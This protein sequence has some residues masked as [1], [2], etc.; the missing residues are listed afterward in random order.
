MADAARFVEELSQV[1]SVEKWVAFDKTYG[2]DRVDT[3]FWP[4]TDWLHQ[5][6]S[7][8]MG[9]EGGVLDLRNYDLRDEAY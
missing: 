9:A 7:A 6:I 5:W 3:E 1:D 8:N 2:I 4:F